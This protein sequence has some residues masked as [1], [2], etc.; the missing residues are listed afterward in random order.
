MPDWGSFYFYPPVTGITSPGLEYD[1]SLI[2]TRGREYA[3]AN[4]TNGLRR[5]GVG[6]GKLHVSQVDDWEAFQRLIKGRHKRFLFI[7]KTRHF[8]MTDSLIGTGNGVTTAF[9][10]KKVSSYP[11]GPT[12]QVSEIVRFPWHDYPPIYLPSSA[13]SPPKYLD[14]EYITVKVDGALQTLTTHY[15]VEREGGLI[16]FVSPP[17]NGAL[18]TASCKFAVL[19]RQSQDFNPIQATS[20]GHL[21]YIIPGGVEIYEP[22]HDPAQR[23][24]GG[25]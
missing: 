2:P 3:N 11:Y 23:L 16:T 1:T 14:T 15:S 10:L 5:I 22:R 6:G 8:A 9:Q 21:S 17:A 12:N 13:G 19:C 4:L 20:E 18:I 7:L 24:D 25:E